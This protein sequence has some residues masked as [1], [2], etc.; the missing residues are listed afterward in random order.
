[1]NSQDFKKHNTIFLNSSMNYNI[2]FISKTK[3]SDFHFVL[4]QMSRGNVFKLSGN[5]ALGGGTDTYSTNEL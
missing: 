2:N 4:Y 3:S 1:M 5:L